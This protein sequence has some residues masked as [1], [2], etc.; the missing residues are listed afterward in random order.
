MSPCKE[1]RSRKLLA[2]GGGI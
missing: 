1:R 2:A